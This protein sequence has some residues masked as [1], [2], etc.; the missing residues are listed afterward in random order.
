[1][2]KLALC[3]V[4]L[5]SMTCAMAQ[6]KSHTVQRG[7]T[8]ES[9]AQKYNVSVSAL[10]SSNPN[11][12][13]AVYVGMKLTIPSNAGSY[14]PTQTTPTSTT[15]SSSSSSS[16][17]SYT[18]VTSSSTKSYGGGSGD[19]GNFELELQAG[20]S[21]NNYTGK[22]GGHDI[23]ADMKV[24]FHGG[25]KG[26]YFF[27]NNFYGE[28]GALFATKGY[29]Y[30]KNGVDATMNTY[31]I[32]IPINVGV[33]FNVADNM[34]LRFF[35]G[36]YLTY[37]FDGELKVKGTGGS[38]D[39]GGNGDQGGDGPSGDGPGGEGPGG[40]QPQGPP[41]GGGQS[42]S[43]RADG[44]GNPPSSGVVDDE[45]P[46]SSGTVTTKLKDMDGFNKFNVG[47][48]VGVSF[49]IGKFVV[50]AQFQRGLGKIYKDSKIYEQNILFTLGYIF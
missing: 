42:N 8:L 45:Q 2:K 46:A 11:A 16:S 48:N 33:S 40:D 38:G 22:E 13:N 19:A 50:S 14:T 25:L 39:Y 49:D 30:K 31:N 32:D 44:P 9:I 27:S 23:N 21:L 3:V 37:A 18:T 4:A 28:I 24:G 15:S 29:K 17:S 1:M 12:A 35:A 7:E 26:R 41:P 47:V 36:P 43:T 34:R 6:Q 10:K 5:L 20:L